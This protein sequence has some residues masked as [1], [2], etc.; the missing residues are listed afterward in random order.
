MF[1][2]LIMVGAL[3]L[4]ITLRILV[5]YEFGFDRMFLNELISEI[6]DRS[7]LHFALTQSIIVRFS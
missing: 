3:C 2:I 5:V 4:I 7:G 6:L 1:L